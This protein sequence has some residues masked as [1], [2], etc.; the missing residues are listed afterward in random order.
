M[1]RGQF[2][3]PIHKSLTD[4]G[5]QSIDMQEIPGG[6]SGLIIDNARLKISER[7]QAWHQREDLSFSDDVK[8]IP[9]ADEMQSVLST[10]SMSLLQEHGRVTDGVLRPEELVELCYTAVNDERHWAEMFYHL[11]LKMSESSDFDT[12]QLDSLIGQLMPHFERSYE[13]S[14]QVMK[15]VILGSVLQDVIDRFGLAMAIVDNQGHIVQA[16]EAF[17]RATP[18]LFD[19]DATQ[20]NRSFAQLIRSQT[21]SARNEALIMYE[22]SAIAFYFQP[23]VLRQVAAKQGGGSGVVLL[24]PVDATVDATANSEQADKIELLRLAYKLTNKEAEVAM[25]TLSGRSQDDGARTLSVSINTFK[26]HLKS[27]YEKLG[28]R[29]QSELT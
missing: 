22:Q 12:E 25:M 27:V 26:T 7:I 24:R 19:A 21:L 14:R 23:P 1:G 2:V 28:V 15:S 13:L 29:G 8:D 3:G 20:A 6:R 4:I 10:L 11:A 9:V 17:N 16:N 18:L 5:F